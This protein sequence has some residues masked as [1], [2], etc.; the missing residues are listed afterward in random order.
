M[1]QVERDKKSISLKTLTSICNTTG[2]SSDYILFGDSSNSS[3]SNRVLKILVQ[4][5]PDAN[6]MVYNMVSSLKNLYENK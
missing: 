2:V 1:S 6:N 5:P 3:I 4:L